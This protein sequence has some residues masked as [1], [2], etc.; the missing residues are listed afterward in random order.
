MKAVL[1]AD[2]QRRE[3]RVAGKDD[4]FVKVRGMGQI[5]H[6]VHDK[7]YVRAG[8]ASWRE[9]VAVHDLEGAAGEVE[10]EFLIALGV[11]VYH[12][13]EDAAA[14]AFAVENAERVI[15]NPA[16]PAVGRCAEIARR[17][18][19]GV[20]KTGIESVKIHVQRAEHFVK[21]GKSSHNI[22]S[23]V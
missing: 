10:T 6:A 12:A 3:I 18:G 8:S 11:Q 14:H 16:N 13:P 20:K 1:E 22:P 23:T 2:E 19:I 17:F 4:E 7:M 9:R 5:G 21:T 15:L